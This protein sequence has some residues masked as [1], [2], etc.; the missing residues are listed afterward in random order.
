[1]KPCRKIT[2]ERKPSYF[3]FFAEISSVGHKERQLLLSNILKSFLC[4]PRITAFM[5]FYL[6]PT[7]LVLR[8]RVFDIHLR[9]RS[10]AKRV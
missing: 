7:A 5:L 8:E 3:Y 6:P 1:M 2:H 10:S 4:I 9:A